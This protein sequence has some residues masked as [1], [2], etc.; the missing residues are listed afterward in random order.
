MDLA[1][2]SQFY[3]LGQYNNAGS[4][5]KFQKRDAKLVFKVDFQDL[6]AT[7]IGLTDI[8]A[9]SQIQGSS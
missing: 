8:T 3:I 7:T 4:I 6:L 9:Y 1:D 5:M 2:N